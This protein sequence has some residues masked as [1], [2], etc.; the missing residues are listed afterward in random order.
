MTRSMT[1]GYL[2]VAAL[3]LLLDAVLLRR[4]SVFLGPGHRGEG[5]Q[6]KLIRYLKSCV[7]LKF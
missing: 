6:F 1:N 7:M 4:E 3:E 2:D 5:L